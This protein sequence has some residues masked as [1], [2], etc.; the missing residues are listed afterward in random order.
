[1]LLARV[2][3]IFLRYAEMNIELDRPGAKLRDE[4]GASYGEITRIALRRHRIHVEGWAEAAR[5]GLAVNSTRAWVVPD[6]VQAGSARRGFALDIPCETGPITLVAERGEGQEPL[7]Q[8][9]PG[10][11]REALLRARAPMALRFVTTLAQLAPVIHRWKRQ[12]DLGARE[13]VKERLGLVPRSDAA[14][15]LPALLPET[16]PAA[17]PERAA[18]LILPVYNAFHLLPEALERIARHS[19]SAWRLLLID[20]ASPDPQVRPFLRDWAAARPQVTLLENNENLGFIGTVN[21]G[22]AEVLKRWPEDPV[23]LVNSD[24]MVPPGWLPRLLAPLADPE[25]ASVTPMSNDAE[26]FTVPV[27]CQRGDLAPGD[28]DALDAVAAGFD[29]KAGLAEAPTGVGFCMALA[30]AFL[31]RIPQFDPIFGRGYGEENDWCRKAVAMGGRHLCAPNLFVEHRGGQSFGSAD[32]QRLLERNLRVLS[33]RYPGY[34][35]EVQEFIRRDPLNT[36]R[37]ALGLVLAARRQ[38]GA[39]PVY[40][41]HALG[42]GAE[43]YLQ[44]RIAAETRAGQSALVLRVGQGHRW[45]L[46]LYGPTGLTQGLT[47]DWDLVEKLVALL[48]ER[49][50]VYSCGVHER[51]ASELPE[52]LLALAA[53]TDGQGAHPVEILMHDFFPVSPSYTLLGA[54]GVYRGVPVAGGALEEDPAHVYERPGG[55][56]ASLRDW[57]AAWGRVMDAAER[58]V[59]FS[60]S[61]RD[62]V[63]QAYPQAAPRIE[64]RPHQ[65]PAT[66]PR[67]APGRGEGGVPVIG[68]LGNIGVQ[69]GAALLQGLSRELARS[70]AARLV[71]LGHIDPSYKLASPSLV[72]G[73]YELRDLP[74]LVARYGI[75]SWFMPSIWPETFSFTTH[76]MLATGLPVVSFDLGA[77]GEAVAR[78]LAQGAP[79]ALLRVPQGP[80]MDPADLLAALQRR[81]EARGSEWSS[82]GIT[83]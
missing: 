66:P 78:A 64:V 41:A 31:A 30:P 67:I 19:G 36:P 4:T 7:R 38:Q 51:D 9:L 22:F 50:I 60:G 40:L 23:V 33:G 49:R 11:S 43:S 46:E 45:K 2:Y 80:R 81:G 39:V 56:M 82:K 77:Q 26:I 8:T 13:V 57:Q 79:G 34:D 54:D 71:V 83:S 69:K 62:I 25:V 44:D 75:S 17:A 70:G 32:K 12:G 73:S 55:V 10:F 63:A 52:R 29:P 59:V 53:R 6:L 74:G 65:L 42:G 16:P 35:A 3:R 68:V 72:H 14:E 28:V 58:V 47:N 21:R 76:E 20:D 24:A 48:P 37:L 61:S 5:I 15:M 18:T 27:I 1:M